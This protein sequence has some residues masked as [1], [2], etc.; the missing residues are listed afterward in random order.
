[1]EAASTIGVSAKS[2]ARWRK[3][4]VGPAYLQLGRKVRYR[5]G[6]V[7]EWIAS[8]VQHPLGAAS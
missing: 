8:Q 4:G 1:M 5:P 3:G 2:L 6:D 7:A